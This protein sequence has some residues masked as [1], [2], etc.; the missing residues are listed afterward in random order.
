MYHVYSAV[1]AP[2]HT[3]RL[4]PTR[5]SSGAVG[6]GATPIWLLPVP[7]ADLPEVEMCHLRMLSS[8]ETPLMRPAE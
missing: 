7:T 3:A 8:S 1:T 5:V 4:I 2:G 6:L